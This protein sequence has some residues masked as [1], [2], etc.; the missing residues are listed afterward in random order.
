M[1]ALNAKVDES[2]LFNEKG[3]QGSGVGVSKANNQ[4]NPVAAAL[5]A[6]LAKLQ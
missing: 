5:Q 3:S 1:K 6:R 2:D 4:S